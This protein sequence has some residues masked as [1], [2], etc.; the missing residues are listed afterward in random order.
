[1]SQTMTFLNDHRRTVLLVLGDKGKKK[2]LLYKTRY[3]QMCNIFIDQA[4]LDKVYEEFYSSE[5]KDFE[6]HLRVTY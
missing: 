6:H 2:G 4:K 3:L 5:M 1:M